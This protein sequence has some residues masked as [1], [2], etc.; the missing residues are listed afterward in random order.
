MLVEKLPVE[1]KTMIAD[2]IR[3]YGISN[4]EYNG[5]PRHLAA[6]VE[7]VLRAWDTHKQEHLW[8]MF[9]HQ[10]ILEK[11]VSYERPRN[12]LES[13]LT[14]AVDTDGSM[15]DFKEA[16]SNQVDMEYAYYSDTA[17]TIRRMFSADC[18]C[19]NRWNWSGDSF[20]LRG[21]KIDVPRGAKIMKVLNKIAKVVH[22]EKEF[23]TFRI[24]HSQ[25]LNQKLLTGTLCLS[26]HPFDYMTLS[27]NDYGW[28]SCMNW[29]DNGCYRTGTV[30][31]M[32]SPYMVVAYL[33]GDKQFR[34]D[35]RYWAGN[36]K[37]RELYV[38]HPQVICNVKAY[39]YQNDVLSQ[40][41]L[42]WL[43]ELAAHNLKWDVSYDACEFNV[44]CAFTYT[45]KRNYRFNMYYNFM[46]NDFDTSNTCHHII[47]P[48]GWQVD[49]PD[50]VNH[51]DINL[52]GPNVCV[53]CGEYWE[54]HEG[55][56]DQVL[57][58]RCDPGIQCSCCHDEIDDE[59]SEYHV[60]GD[61]LCSY[62]FEDSA[63]RCAITE[64]YYYNDN[65]TT[66]YCL[67]IDDDLSGGTYALRSC[68]VANHFVYPN[69]LVHEPMFGVD[70]FHQAK[71]KYGHTIYYVNMSECSP[72]ALEDCFGLWNERVRSEY[73]NYYIDSIEQE[74]QYNS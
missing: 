65:M 64:D 53:C 49:D 70:T 60:E 35:S 15:Y 33:K 13:Q 74:K 3:W 42:E 32:N 11:E 22:L 73:I 40:L 4:R 26:I 25:I 62:C 16:L 5:F 27:D 56:E 34:I 8:D 1:D 66:I 59:D 37:W 6:P 7:Y 68:T 46:Y 41:A 18:L 71:D 63:G 43:R 12:L 67:P 30:E 39:P 38:V 52:S 19:D 54:P 20:T 58:R 9:G 21:T 50:A 47:V 45:D 44:D 10:F 57:C 17:R 72:Y 29:V 51:V 31:M 2:W 55:H 28:D 61:T 36:K 69:A 24:A 48:Q 14:E 23:E